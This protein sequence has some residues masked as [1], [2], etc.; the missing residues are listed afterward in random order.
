MPLFF[1][2]FMVPSSVNVAAINCAD[3]GGVSFAVQMGL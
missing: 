2:H 3:T 1:V